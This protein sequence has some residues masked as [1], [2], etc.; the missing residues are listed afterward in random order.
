MI[1]SASSGAPGAAP[2]QPCATDQQLPAA[3]LRRFWV[4]LRAW[5]WPWK[6]PDQ[7]RPPQRSWALI[8][9]WALALLVLAAVERRERRWIRVVLLHL[10]LLPPLAWEDQLRQG[11]QLLQLLVES[12]IL[13]VPLEQC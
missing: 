10:L 7:G 8:L 6:Q 4:A 9:P 13:A 12:Q 11:R 1:A 3:R 5:V 2:R